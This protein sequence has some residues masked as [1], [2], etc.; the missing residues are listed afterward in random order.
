MTAGDSGAECFVV[1]RGLLKVVGESKDGNNALLAIR[2]P[3]DVVGEIAVLDGKP[4]SATVVAAVQTW[5]RVISGE[6]L[7]AHL[8]ERPTTAL[9]FNRMTT[10]KLRESTNHRTD[11]NGA[12]VV[13]R[14]ARVMQRLASEYGED[15]AE[16]LFIGVPLSQADLAGLVGSTE[17]SVRR[18]LSALR[19]AE[20]ISTRY[21]R[22][23]VTD[24]YRL[25]AVAEGLT[26][27]E[28]M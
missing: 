23:F 18:A 10:A 21:R 8:V 17:Q 26:G 19:E 1:M 16:G 22:V 15:T 12:P 7:L 5:T 20:V 14:L 24:A 11:L 13:L 27:L 4:R 2:V 6:R 3:G 28:D 25:H 9:A